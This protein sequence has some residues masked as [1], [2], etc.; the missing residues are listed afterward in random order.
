MNQYDNMMEFM[1]GL[2]R[3]NGDAW[4]IE[5]HGFPGVDNLG[6][7]SQNVQSARISGVD[8]QIMGE[9]KITENLGFTIFAGSSIQIK[10][11]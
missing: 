6:A 5:Q 3:D 1:F 4:D 7:Q 10:Q 2:Y 9:G 8:F 11:F